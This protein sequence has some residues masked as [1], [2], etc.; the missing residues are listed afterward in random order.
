M[1]A[2][3]KILYYRKNPINYSAKFDFISFHSPF[4][5]KNNLFFNGRGLEQ[6]R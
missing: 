2:N 1:E 5:I 3:Q 6:K 4:F